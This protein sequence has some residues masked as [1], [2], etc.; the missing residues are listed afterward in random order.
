MFSNRSFFDKIETVIGVT[1]N[2]VTRISKDNVTTNNGAN[3]IDNPFHAHS[4]SI[5]ITNGIV[6]RRFARYNKAD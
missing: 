2:V 1:I 4:H 6:H 3:E 5:V